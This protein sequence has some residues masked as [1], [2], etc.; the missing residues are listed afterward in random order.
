MQTSPS[1]LMEYKQHYSRNEASDYLRRRGFNIAPSTL[2][3]YEVTEEGPACRTSGT[4]A[5]YYV[6]DLDAWIAQSLKTRC[7]SISKYQR[8]YSRTEASEYLSSQGLKFPPYTL[9]KYEVTGEGP[10]YQMLG[11]RVVYDWEDLDAWIEQCL[12]RDI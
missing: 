9:A 8:Y 10:V 12:R 11:T 4:G 5:V 1:E 2:A 7:R 6:A 3:R